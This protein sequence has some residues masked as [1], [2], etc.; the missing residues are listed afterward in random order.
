M[1][2]FFYGSKE[3]IY[4][5]PEDF[6][7]FVKHLLPRWVNGIPD[8]EFIAMYRIINNFSKA[9]KPQIAVETGCGASSLILFFNAVNTNGKLYSWDTNGS[10]LSYLRAVI[11]EAICIPLEINVNEYWQTISFD[12]TS[13][14]AGISM[15]RDMGVSP[16]IGFF[17][18]YHSW[19]H[20]KKEVSR[21][22]AIQSDSDKLVMIDD[23][24]Y[25][26]I[27]ENYAYGNM[28]R[29]KVGLPPIS[30]PEVNRGATFQTRF[31]DEFSG[32][33][34]SI[35]VASSDLEKLVEDDLFFSYYSADRRSMNSMA[36]EDA[37]KL[38]SRLAAW[39][40]TSLQ[41]K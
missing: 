5:N 33:L 3:D 12:S 16:N 21:F 24:Y 40:V 11:N 1:F 35:E 19:S 15:L 36:M 26:A 2:D 34:Y 39:T 10:K 25:N 6:L 4:E 30:E 20:L 31:E 9:E 37:S 41:K 8:S 7:V 13:E 14:I 27:F 38:G 17:D 18:S 23:A 28:I 29:R 32:D 22:L